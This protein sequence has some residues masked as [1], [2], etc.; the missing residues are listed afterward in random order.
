MMKTLFDKPARARRSDPP[1][2]HEAAAAIEAMVP[3]QKVTV[4]RALSE[5]GPCSSR[6]LAGVSGLDRYMVARRLPEMERDGTVVRMGMTKYAGRSA[7]LWA[8]VE[9]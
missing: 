7:V 3:N 8:A 5:N 1:S 9:E 6:G 2:S 4:F